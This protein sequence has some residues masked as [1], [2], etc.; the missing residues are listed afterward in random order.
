MAK[1]IYLMGA[2][3][4]GKDTLLNYLKE[5]HLSDLAYKYAKNKRRNNTNSD[6][7]DTDLTKKKIIV[8]HRYV[9]HHH[10]TCDDNQIF[11]YENDFQ[12]RLENSF[13]VMAWKANNLKYAVG[14]EV[15][16]WVH[17]GH[18]VIVQGSRT[19]LPVAKKT[20]GQSLIPVC[21]N[22][23]EAILVERLLAEGRENQRSIEQRLTQA[24]IYANGLPSDTHFINND[25]DIRTLTLRL[26]DLVNSIDRDELS[27]RLCEA[28]GD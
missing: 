7:Q 22:V 13:F 4:S 23:P 10:E 17:G 20:F 25:C 14:R 26:Y 27:F 1:L 28:L 11:L 12:F 5:H 15:Y 6:F 16:H 21:L 19:H 8:A 9:T 3:G 18:N 2:S 24:R